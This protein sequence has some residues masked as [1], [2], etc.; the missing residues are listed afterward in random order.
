MSQTKFKLGAPPRNFAK[1]IELVQHDGNVIEIAF[2]L[3]YRT[4]TGLAELMDHKFSEQQAAVKAAAL[5]P[6]DQDAETE[7][8]AEVEAKPISVA[9]IVRKNDGELADWVMRLVDGWD[10]DEPFNKVNLLKLEDQFPGTMGLIDA[11]YNKAVMERRVK[12]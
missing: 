3:I 7:V 8:A 11:A 5:P 10:L 2:S 1:T 9:E 4:R 12:N 6:A